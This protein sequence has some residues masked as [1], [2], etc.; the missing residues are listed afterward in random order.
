LENL[1]R[2]GNP[3]VQAIVKNWS[4]WEKGVPETE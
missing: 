2:T 3:L 4:A 1:Y